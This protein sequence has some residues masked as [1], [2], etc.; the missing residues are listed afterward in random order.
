MGDSVVVIN[1][2]KI[3]LTGKKLDKKNYY[4]HSGYI[5]GLKSVTARKLIEKTPRRRDPVR[6]QGHAAQKQPG[7]QVVQEA[8]GL[9]GG[10]A[11]P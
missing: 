2:E 11:S 9:R 1:A 8:E 7:P 4:R 3:V 5:G 6:R 10:A